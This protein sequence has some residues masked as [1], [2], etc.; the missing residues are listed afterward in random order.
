MFGK[1]HTSPSTSMPRPK[2]KAERGVIRWAPS[3][4][5]NTRE[6][7]FSLFGEEDFDL[8]REIYDALKT[9]GFEVDVFYIYEER[10]TN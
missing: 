4:S 7:S 3:Y 6:I 2:A 8:G 5:G 9:A 10:A 1:K